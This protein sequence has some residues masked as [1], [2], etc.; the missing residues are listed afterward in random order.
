MLSSFAAELV[1]LKMDVLVTFGLIPTRAAREATA[2]IPIV[3]ACTFD[4]VERGLVESL[5]QPGGNLTGAAG[6]TVGLIGKQFELAS[7]PLMP[8]NLR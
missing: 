4:P 7:Q 6:T 1:R 8:E 5:A 2:T 3:F